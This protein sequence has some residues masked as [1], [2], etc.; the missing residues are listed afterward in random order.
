MMAFARLLGSF[1]SKATQSLCQG[2]LD[3]ASLAVCSHQDIFRRLSSHAEPSTPDETQSSGRDIPIRAPNSNGQSPETPGEGSPQP[4]LVFSIKRGGNVHKVGGA[5]AME[6][7]KG[8]TVLAQATGTEPVNVTVKALCIG[9]GY[10]LEDPGFDLCFRVNH[11][12]H[13]NR[14]R[15]SQLSFS[16]EATPMRFVP[17]NPVEELRVT[18]ESKG[19][20]IGALI[21]STIQNNRCPTLRAVG[22]KSVGNMMVGATWARRLLRRQGLDVLCYPSFK[23]INIEDKGDRTSVEVDFRSVAYTH[24]PYIDFPEEDGAVEPDVREDNGECDDVDYG[25]RKH[26]KQSLGI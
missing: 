20:G 6:L 4:P 24:V 13:N 23:T 7:R 17:K 16:V 3:A 11:Q 1:P 18:A 25:V 21:A 15:I 26:L 5:I 12:P 8:K 10:V 2:V 22:P 9:R 14:E 19:R